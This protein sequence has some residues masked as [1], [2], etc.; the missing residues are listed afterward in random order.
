MVRTFVASLLPAV[1]VT[2]A[3]LGL[4]QP[5]RMGEAIGL[6]ALALTPALVP[7][8]PRRIG[9]VVA[10][11]LGAAWAV[12]AAE[13]WEL[14]PFR[15]ERVL[16]PVA[17]DIARG[18]VDFYEVFLPFEPGPNPEMHALVLS[19][20]FGFSLAIGLLVAARRPIAAAAVTVAGVGWPATLLGGTAIAVGV[21]A[22]AAALSIPLLLRASALRTALAGALLGALVVAGAAWTSSVTTL[23]REAALDWESWDIRG[24]TSPTSSVRFAWDSNYDGIEFPT[25]RTVVF[26]VKGPEAATYWRASTL[27]L[28][29]DEHWFEHLFWITRVE[30]GSRVALANGPLLTNGASQRRNWAEP[31]ATGGRGVGLVEQDVEVRAFVDDRLV[32]AGTPLAIDARRLGTVFQ[33]SGNV[34]RT[35]DSLRAGTT[36]RIWSHVPD[37][38]P[39]ELAAAPDRYPSAASRYLEVDGRQFPAF[40]LERREQLVDEFFADP[41]YADFRRYRP[42]YDAAERVA[43]D[44]RTPYETVLALE[45]WFRQRGGFRYD[46][47][48]P[49]LATS[50]LV[51]FVT[52][53]KAGY[54]QHFAGAMAAMLRMLGVPARVAVGFTSG[55]KRAE[56]TWIVTDHEAHAW[57]EV[58][59]PGRG[60]IPFDPTPGRGTFGGAYSFAS[61]S[62]EAVAALRRGELAES[63][64]NTRS[65]REPDAGDL[66]GGVSGAVDDRAP[67]IVAIALLLGALWIGVVGVGKAAVRRG[68]YLSRDPRRVATASRLELEEFLRDQGADV[69]ANAGLVALQRAVHDE[70]GLDGRPYAIAAARARFGPPSAVEHGAATARSEVRR[71]I[72]AARRELTLW[73]R[74]RGLVSLRS[75]RLGGS[76]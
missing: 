56:N 25:A 29:S 48:P 60:W 61:D 19:A 16:A 75:L 13:P 32:A 38:S 8:G 72:G 54:C 23:A 66:Q 18:I 69:P 27:N 55:Q 24:E 33:L 34:L 57:V 67:S 20:I 36:Y 6:A 41:A 3:W 30:G 47:S 35:R 28:F 74:F 15:D 70:L 4:E 58:W 17:S 21:L 53:T 5:R 76:V 45:S 31:S 42:M 49:R 71:L 1:V 44:A 39:A 10:V 26:T 22:L 43:R 51:G 68:R 50:P 73:A 2:A 62:N 59:F 65:L 46:E 7:S 40:G 64:P 11:A 14:L 12:F 9:A 52:R 37:P 63:T